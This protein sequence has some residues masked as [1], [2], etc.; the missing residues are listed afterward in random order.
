MLS[1]I[2]LCKHFVR[3]KLNLFILRINLEENF[4]REM[5]LLDDEKEVDTSNS[6]SS[7]ELT[8]VD[9]S[10]LKGKLGKTHKSILSRYTSLGRLGGAPTHP[11]T[12]Q[13]RN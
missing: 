6:E 10:A 13:C 9:E 1:G 5:D 2:H 4:E 11:A 12:N 7:N 3:L 8:D